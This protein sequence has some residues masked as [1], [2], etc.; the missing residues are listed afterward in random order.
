M[1]VN[2]IDEDRNTGSADAFDVRVTNGTQTETITVT[3]T[4]NSTGLF[5]GSIAT[6]FSLGST[7][8][9]N[10]VQARAWDT[11]PF[12]YDDSLDAD[13]E[14][15][16]RCA[17]TSVI[18]GTNGQIRT[19]VVSQPGDTVR[20]RVEDADLS[21]SVVVTVENPRTSEVEF[22]LLSI[23]TPGTS[24]FY[25]RIFTDRG[26]AAGSPGD[27]VLNV[28]KADVLL[29]TYADTLTA[30]GG[31]VTVPDDNEV[32]DPFGDADGNGLVQAYDAAL[33]L[34]H[35]LSTYS[36]GDGTLSGLD[37]LSANVDQ[38]AP[39]GIIDGYD[40]SLILQKVVGLIGRFE[41]QE[42]DA[43]NH[44]QPETNLLPK[45]VLEERRLALVP[46]EGYVSVW[47]ADREGIVSGELMLAGVQGQ[48][49]MGAELEAF[50]TA[51]QVTDGGM[52]V[53]FAGAEGMSG[54]G[55][56]LRV[57]GVGSG[58]A[59]LTRV[60]FNGGRIG[61]R[62]EEGSTSVALPVSFVL[63]PNH[64]NP[65]NPET[66]IRYDVPLA[67]RVRLRIYDV[68]GQVVRELTDAFQP[69]GSY[70]IVWDGR[71]ERGDQVAN[72]VYLYELRAGDYRAISKM[73]LMK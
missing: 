25:G 56:L 47:C 15:E 61:A 52:Q 72:S 49:V 32:V 70:S 29:I 69:A 30:N 27:D 28:L 13:G 55:E 68:T 26:A 44:P 63:Y 20:V 21:E 39:F 48:V 17:T 42:P 43:D 14:T 38:A 36:G 73:V 4:G 23:F 60:S 3:E 45:P 24:V 54:P 18:G 33:V 66:T 34:I 50:L 51:S 5:E 57:A 64:P 12:C 1:A 2:D 19:T 40:A 37:S 6:V 35:R 62:W 67:D 53:V 11:I 7:S 22:I 9:D 58:D 10:V 65:F 46:G 16:E 59:R 8:G 71:N 31:M 41:V